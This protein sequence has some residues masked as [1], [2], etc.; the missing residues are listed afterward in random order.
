VFRCTNPRLH[1][2]VMPLHGIEQANEVKLIGVI[3]SNNLR[4]DLQF[5]M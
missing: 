2:D 4:F 3:F 5:C 1:V